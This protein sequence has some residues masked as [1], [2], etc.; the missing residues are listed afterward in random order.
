M[1]NRVQISLEVLAFRLAQSGPDDH[2]MVDP[3]HST[4][5]GK[6]ADHLSAEV[7]G[8]R[9]WVVHHGDVGEFSVEVLKGLKVDFISQGL[10]GWYLEC[11]VWVVYLS[12]EVSMLDLDG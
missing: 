6:H 11:G 5:E 7:S 10:K 1:T 4:L 8:H 3:L 9:V 12:G 2:V